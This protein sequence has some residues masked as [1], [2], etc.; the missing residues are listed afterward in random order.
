MIGTLPTQ[1]LALPSLFLIDFSAN[2][3][4][5]NLAGSF[6][7]SNN[8][9]VASDADGSSQSGKSLKA[10]LLGRNLLSGSLPSE[11]AEFTNLQVLELYKNKLGGS[12]PSELASLVN[13]TALDLSGNSLKGVV[14]TELGSLANIRRLLLFDNALTGDIPSELSNLSR[15]QILNLAK[16]NFTTQVVGDLC[17]LKSSIIGVD[18]RNVSCECC[19]CCDDKFC[20]GDSVVL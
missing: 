2:N 1:I 15:L 8:S 4:T 10:L 13:L 6:A 18:C 12:I 5:G 11:I 19:S 3:L 9:S 7:P 17:V 20:E 16:N 14:P